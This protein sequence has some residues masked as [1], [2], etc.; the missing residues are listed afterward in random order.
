MS[1]S[2]G[3]V[4]FCSLS[5]SS[6]SLSLSHPSLLLYHSSGVSLVLSLPPHLS[7]VCKVSPALFA[8]AFIISLFRLPIL[9]K[10]LHANNFF[11]FATSHTHTDREKP[12]TAPHTCVASIGTYQLIDEV[13]KK[14]LRLIASTA[15][16]RTKV[17][18][19]LVFWHSGILLAIGKD[20]ALIYDLNEHISCDPKSSNDPKGLTRKLAHSHTH[21]RTA[22]TRVNI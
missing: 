18:L 10:N 4:L 19:S 2:L 13:G 20:L 22:L 14:F 7:V 1:Q 16:K 3:S 21:A 15:T 5:S 11:N 9:T 12:C 8:L 17:F 6:T